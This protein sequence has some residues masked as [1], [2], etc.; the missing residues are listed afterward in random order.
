MSS[1]LFIGGTICIVV[2]CFVAFALLAV[3]SKNIIPALHFAGY[4]FTLS[5]LL[6]IL[7]Y[8]GYN[9]YAPWI[10][11]VFTGTLFLLFIAWLVVPSN[12]KTPRR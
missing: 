11:F 6:W 4:A 2:M 7:V 1:N 12:N 8:L 9:G 10:A 3:F 5:M